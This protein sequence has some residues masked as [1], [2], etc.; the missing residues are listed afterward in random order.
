MWIGKKMWICLVTILFFTSNSIAAEPG[1]K[2]GIL[3]FGDQVRYME[4]IRGFID[5]LKEAG[6]GEPQAQFTIENAGSNKAVAAELVKKIAAAKFDL[7]FTAGTHATL[8][9][10]QE[11]KDVPIVFAQVYDPVEAGIAKSWQNSGNNTTGVSTRISMSQLIGHLKQLRP[12]NNL[13]VLYTPGEKN[14]E[15]QLI[16]LQEI[17]GNSGVNIVPVPLAKTEDIEQILPL[18]MVRTDAVYITGS[19]FVNNHLSMVLNVAIKGKIITVSHLEDLVEKGVL[20]GVGPN[21]YIVGRLAGKK[22][23]RIFEGEL[24]STIPIE[25]SKQLDVIINMK[26]VQAGGFQIPPE[27]MKTVSKKIE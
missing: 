16:D 11:I 3:T 14:S 12:V 17:Q 25:T 26:T 6:L 24:P 18:L 8:A 22:A 5:T 21:P 20:L 2:I 15:S 4:S 19:N 23:I 10:S 1:K 13:A 9:V 7:I 27:F